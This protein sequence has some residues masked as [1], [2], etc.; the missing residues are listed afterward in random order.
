V[1]TWSWTFGDGGT[2]TTRNPSHTYAA[3]GSYGVTLIA[4]DN[5]GTT[6]SITQTVT[7]AAPL[8]TNAPPIANFTSSC[9]GLTCSFTD[10]STDSDG[11]VTAWS[12]TFGDAGSSTARNPSYT[13]AS[14]GT[15]TVTLT[16]TDDDGAPNQRSV[17]VTVTAP[18]VAAPR[19]SDSFNRVVATGAGTA[20]GGSDASKTWV[21][22]E[23]ANPDVKVDGSA[24]VLTKD[25]GAWRGLVGTESSANIDGSLEVSSFNSD[26]ALLGFYLRVSGGP[27][28]NYQFQWTGGALTIWRSTTAGGDVVLATVGQA[29]NAAFK[30][31][32]QVETVG[33]SV[34]LRLKY[35]T[36]G[37]EPAAWTLTATDTSPSRIM[38]G[39]YGLRVVNGGTSD[40]R[41]DNFVADNLVAQLN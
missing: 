22:W 32:V 3:A 35:W 6:G 7:V 1:T 28:D 27:A 38:S 41:I 16:V 34:I 11:S 24:L 36:G 10:G 29:R 15:F 8:P 21:T 9:T 23:G 4:T 40:M 26:A 39:A 14:G 20:D 5:S 18:P 25:A 31:R 17:P 37:T 19:F 33:T 12:W 30:L 13:Y 2:S